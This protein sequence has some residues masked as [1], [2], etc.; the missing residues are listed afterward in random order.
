M[1]YVASAD[2]LKK[3]GKQEWDIDACWAVEQKRLSGD[4][5]NTVARL[6]NRGEHG[7]EERYHEALTET[8]ILSVKSSFHDDYCKRPSEAVRPDLIEKGRGEI[9]GTSPRKASVTA[10]RAIFWGS[11]SLEGYF[12]GELVRNQE[13]PNSILFCALFIFIGTWLAG[14]GIGRYLIKNHVEH[15]SNNLLFN[16]NE[17][18]ENVRESNITGLEIWFCT[19]FGKLIFGVSLWFLVK[20]SENPS[21]MFSIGLY[22]GLLILISEAL[23][24]YKKEIRTQ[25]L[26]L[27]FT[28]QTMYAIEKHM[29]NN[30]S[31]IGGKLLPDDKFARK[32][33]D[34]II[35]QYS[36]VHD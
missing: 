5:H 19:I 17:N 34:E 16:I 6:L 32:Y 4:L 7:G 21:Y 27:M 24:S 28:A 13:E 14:Y 23:H 35:R 31:L 1:F 33:T 9:R 26:R 2:E 18:N 25:L 8:A 30:P 3:E 12:F 15:V 36:A 11:V 10:W 22:S 20:Q 29:Q